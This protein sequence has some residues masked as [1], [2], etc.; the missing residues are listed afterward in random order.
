MVR[1]TQ[2]IRIIRQHAFKTTIGKRA[3]IPSAKN[4]YFPGSES[5][6]SETEQKPFPFGAGWSPVGGPTGSHPEAGNRKKIF[7]YHWKSTIPEKVGFVNG[8]K[9]LKTDGTKVLSKMEV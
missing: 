8:P 4:I 3:K 6:N 5:G 7:E 9:P 2:G 1:I